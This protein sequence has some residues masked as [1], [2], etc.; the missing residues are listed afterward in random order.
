[1]SNRIIKSEP[2][3]NRKKIIIVIVIIMINIIKARIIKKKK[4]GAAD[5]VQCE[6]GFEVIIRMCIIN[7][8]RIDSMCMYMRLYIRILHFLYSGCWCYLWKDRIACPMAIQYGSHH[9]LIFIL[10]LVFILFIS[11]LFDYFWSL[12]PS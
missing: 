4:Q 8:G 5:A 1:M 2:Q 12:F 11:F 7:G 3:Q 6:I 9:F 10:V